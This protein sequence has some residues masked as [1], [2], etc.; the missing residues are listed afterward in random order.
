MLV[1]GLHCTEGD[2]VS[3]N[4]CGPVVEAPLPGAVHRSATQG[5]GLSGSHPQ[6][7]RGADRQVQGDGGCRGAGAHPLTVPLTSPHNASH[8]PS[9]SA[10]C[11]LIVWLIILAQ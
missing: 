10:M 9:L 3:S 11:C 6:D 1:G 4:R 2:R 7:D 5:P 8:L